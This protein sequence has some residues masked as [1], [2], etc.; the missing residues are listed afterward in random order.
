MLVLFLLG[1][2]IPCIAQSTDPAS[3]AVVQ[4]FRLF[5]A[6]NKADSIYG[7]YSLAMQAAV[8]PAAS[9]KLISTLLAQLGNITGTDSGVQDAAPAGNGVIR[10]R[11]MFQHPL[12]DLQLAVQGLK[13]AGIHALAPESADKIRGSSTGVRNGKDA[14]A[15]AGNNENNISVN[16][17]GVEIVGTITLPVKKGRVPV[18]L[19]ISGSGPT[20][21]NGNSPQLGLNTNAYRMLAEGLSAK[22]I[23][24]V[25]YDKRMI[26]DSHSGQEESQLRFDEYIHDAEQFIELLK[27]DPRFTEV[28]VLGHSEGSVIG[29]VA[30]REKKATAFISLCGPAENML[31]IVKSQYQRRLKG[32]DSAKLNDIISSLAAGKIYTGT[33]PASLQAVFRPSV[34]PYLLSELKYDPIEEMGSLKIPVLI[35]AGSSDIQVHLD[36]AR[37]LSKANPLASLVEIQGM[38]HI[39]KTS[40]AYPA[41]NVRTYSD[42][43]LPLAE[44]LIPVI[45]K[46]IKTTEVTE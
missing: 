11:I 46:F 28:I 41:K 1:T 43:T 42:S 25:R 30:S 12:Q 2:V 26:G 24:S 18:L 32:Q 21:R 3:Q 45:V 29:T 36:Q 7:L 5:Y 23:A 34:Q 8:T 35:I 31:K 19:V 44:K 10:Y 33:I 4:K 13:I 14:P 17:G 9:R 38:N 40:P 15:V 16:S 39:L 22:G 37:A 27:K 20:D 6:E